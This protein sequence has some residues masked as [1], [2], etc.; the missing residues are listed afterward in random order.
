MSR[1][2]NEL[3]FWPVSVSKEWNNT[4]RD[5]NQLFLYQ[6]CSLNMSIS[7]STALVWFRLCTPGGAVLTFVKE[8][9]HFYVFTVQERQTKVNT[10]VVYVGLVSIWD[11]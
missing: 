7:D 1:K 3:Y 11:K 8:R 10:D 6:N 4:K 5:T 2:C 9:Y